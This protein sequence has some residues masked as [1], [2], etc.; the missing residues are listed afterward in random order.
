MFSIRNAM[1]DYYNSTENIGLRLSGVMTFLSSRVYMQYHI[2]K[3]A[4]WKKTGGLT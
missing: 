2:N 4:R 3:I 1:E